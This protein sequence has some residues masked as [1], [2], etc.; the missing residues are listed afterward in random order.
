MLGVGR[1][2]NH[3]AY[4]QCFGILTLILLPF[5]I[6]D[7]TNH[8]LLPNV[9]HIRSFRSQIAADGILKEYTFAAVFGNAIDPKRFKKP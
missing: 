6:S 1:E 2:E 8:K 7:A 9:K 4:C 3:N 5:I